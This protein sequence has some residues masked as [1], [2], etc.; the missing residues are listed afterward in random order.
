LLKEGGTVTDGKVIEPGYY[1]AR[2]TFNDE[3][4]PF[5]AI[6]DGG[7]FPGSLIYVPVNEVEIGPR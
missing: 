5:H 2:T 1:W 6:D 3:W 4:T 7:Y